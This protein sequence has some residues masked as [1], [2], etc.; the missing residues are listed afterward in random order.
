MCRQMNM[1]AITGASM[2]NRCMC[3]KVRGS[4]IRAPSDAT[5]SI[6]PQTEA[7]NR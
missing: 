3:V 4:V 6:S 2:A 1:S 7:T 5:A